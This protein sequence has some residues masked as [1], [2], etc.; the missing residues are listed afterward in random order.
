MS[1]RFLW[2]RNRCSLDL[3]RKSELL[4]RLLRSQ[5]IFRYSPETEHRSHIQVQSKM[6]IINIL[7][8]FALVK[9]VQVMQTNMLTKIQVL[10][11]TG[12]VRLFHPSEFDVSV[13]CSC[14][15]NRHRLES[16]TSCSSMIHHIVWLLELQT[17]SIVQLLSIC[18]RM[19][20]NNSLR[21]MGKAAQ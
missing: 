19:Q 3:F 14:L 8:L 6:K 16:G 18:V 12:N 1:Q 4:Q 20:V 9:N 11:S 10:N 2:L 17:K 15:S 7:S 5:I 21:L 13:N